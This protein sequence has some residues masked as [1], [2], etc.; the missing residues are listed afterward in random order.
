[1]IT[2]AT[3]YGDGVVKLAGAVNPD[4]L[5]ELLKY[6]FET[7]PLKDMLEE[8]ELLPE[9]TENAKDKLRMVIIARAWKKNEEEHN[10]ELREQQD[11]LDQ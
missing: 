7:Q 5:V 10:S 4:E 2:T 3:F 9:Q 1:M 8:A 6:I 11:R